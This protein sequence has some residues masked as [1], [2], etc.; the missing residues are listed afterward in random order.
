VTIKRARKAID[1]NPTYS[2]VD[3]IY[4]AKLLEKSKKAQDKFDDNIKERIITTHLI[5]KGILPSSAANKRAKKEDMAKG[6]GSNNL[7][8]LKALQKKPEL[9]RDA[10]KE[11]F[12]MTIPLTAIEIFTGKRPD[13]PLLLLQ[14]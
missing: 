12:F 2:Q 14:N 6:L 7:K 3:T 9:T 4:F 10:L 11:G 5:N 1:S 13:G 8:R